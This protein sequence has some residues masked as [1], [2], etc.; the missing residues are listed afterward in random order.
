MRVRDFADRDDPGVHR[1]L[2][3]DSDEQE[4][5]DGH[6]SSADLLASSYALQLEQMDLIQEAV[7]VLLHVESSVGCVAKSSQIEITCPNM[8][9]RREKAIK[10]LLARSA[11][12]LDDWMTRGIA[13]SLKI[14]LA[15]VNEA[16]VF[17]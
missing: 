4:R 10:D 5:V 16:K 12:K 2:D 7:F 15:W 3:E 6:S 13:G 14:P 11:P 8:D 9:F 17:F 1:N